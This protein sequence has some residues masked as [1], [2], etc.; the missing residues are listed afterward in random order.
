MTT[1]W[2]LLL[3]LHHRHLHHRERACRPFR[4]AAA[5]EWALR[6][7]S[8]WRQ[9]EWALRRREGTKAAAPRHRAASRHAPWAA[10]SP[11]TRQRQHL[12]PCLRLLLPPSSSWLWCP[13]AA[14]LAALESPTMTSPLRPERARPPE[15]CPGRSSWPVPAVRW[16]E[17]WPAPQR[18][19]LRLPPAA[20]CTRP[21]PAPPRE[22]PLR[23]PH[24]RSPLEPRPPWPRRTCPT[25][26]W[27]RAAVNH[28]V[29]VGVWSGFGGSHR[30][31]AGPPS[32]QRPSAA[33]PPPRSSST[34]RRTTPRT[35]SNRPTTN[36]HA[37]R[38]FVGVARED[39]HE[40][41]DAKGGAVGC[42]AS[43]R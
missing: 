22:Q 17:P 19:R 16:R 5:A 7:C 30:Q 37:S 6:G 11:T 4:T 36:K 18:V 15:C 31:P 41:E 24:P 39:A 28:T 42:R 40:G 3:R 13:E 2:R 10:A 38:S 20:A 33:S 35:A 12:P 23:R 29:S 21:A 34:H 9:R 43:R 26:G 14:P 27:R 32:V 25:L 8:R 1:H